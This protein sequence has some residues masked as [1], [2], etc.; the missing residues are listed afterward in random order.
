MKVV[1]STSKKAYAEMDKESM[2]FFILRSVQKY[3]NKTGL[4]LAKLLNFDDPNKVR[5]RL[6]EL[7]HLGFVK[8]VRTRKC[9]ISGK[10]AYTWEIINKE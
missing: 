9:S 3:P 7:L 8:R 6:T 5:P 10:E 1:I 4:E 2:R